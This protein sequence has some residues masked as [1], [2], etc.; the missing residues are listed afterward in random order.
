MVI[1]QVILIYHLRSYL[2][3][4]SLEDDVDCVVMLPYPSD[5]CPVWRTS[6][7][8]GGSLALRWWPRAFPVTMLDPSA[9][10][11]LVIVWLSPSRDVE[12]CELCE[13]GVPLPDVTAPAPCSSRLFEG[14]PRPSSCPQDGSPLELGDSSVLWGFWTVGLK[15]W[16]V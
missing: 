9:K 2:L 5:S 15:T 13:L 16:I 12:A 14:R 3:P 10:A 4:A 11:S 7:V 1:I 6:L 8:S